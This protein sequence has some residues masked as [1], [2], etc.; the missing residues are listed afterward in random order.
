[1]CREDAAKISKVCGEQLKKLG[2][3]LV[4]VLHEEKDGIGIPGL[5]E[6]FTGELY[7]DE[8]KQFFGERFGSFWSLI[9]F[10]I[11]A[12]IRRAIKSGYKH[13]P[14]ANT[15]LLGSIVVVTKGENGEIKYYHLEEFF[16]DHVEP[17]ELMAHVN[18][19]VDNGMLGT[20]KGEENAQEEA[21]E[22][23]I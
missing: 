8:E 15:F 17:E 19:F 7:L 14:G 2:V 10:R 4:G 20:S 18:Y 21:V 6:Y 3:R 5:K 16:G 1:M 23:S 9:S 12:H 22:N 13:V 11:L